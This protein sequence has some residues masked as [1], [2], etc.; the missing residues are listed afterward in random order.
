MN[1]F[2]VLQYE[3]GGFNVKK[4]KHIDGIFSTLEKAVE[5]LKT[6]PINHGKYY[7]ISYKVDHTPQ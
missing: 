4:N 6:I 3:P 5:Y 7:I 1:V 2:V